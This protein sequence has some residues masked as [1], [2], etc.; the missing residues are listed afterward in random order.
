MQYGYTALHYAAQSKH[1]RIM[2]QLLDAGADKDCKDNHDST[3]LHV[4]AAA[5]D[6]HNVVICLLHRGANKDARNKVNS[7][8]LSIRNSIDLREIYIISCVELRMDGVRYIWQVVR[9]IE[10]SRNVSL[11]KV[12]NYKLRL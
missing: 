2:E 3:P 11:M 12:Q 5:H 8:I 10:T 1:V 9:D 4:A 7:F 6:D